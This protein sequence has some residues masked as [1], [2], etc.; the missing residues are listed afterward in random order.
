MF[1]SDFPIL[2]LKKLME[3]LKE[4]SIVNFQLILLIFWGRILSPNFLHHT[5]LGETSIY[6]I[7]IKTHPL[8]VND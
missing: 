1:Y 2:L 4:N 3:F 7:K 5:E 8:Q 6:L